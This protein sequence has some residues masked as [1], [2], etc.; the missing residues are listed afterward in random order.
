MAGRT[1]EETVIVRLKLLNEK[2]G[3]ATKRSGELLSNFKRKTEDLKGGFQRITEV[4]SKYNKKLD[5]IMQTTKTSIKKNREFR[6]EL[7][8]IMFGAKMV[9]NAMGNLL[10]PALSITGI[11]DLLNTVLTV[12]F[13]PTA[14]DLLDF[15]IYFAE[16]FIGLPEPVQKLL[17][18]FAMLMFAFFT[19]MSAKAAMGLFLDSLNKAVNGLSFGIKGLKIGLLELAGGYYLIK[20]VMTIAKEGFTKDAIADLMLGAG[21]IIIS[22][23]PLVGSFLI[24]GAIL[25]KLGV[26]EGFIESVKEVALAMQDIFSYKPGSALSHLKKAALVG[27]G[28]KILPKS[29]GVVS[30]AL[31]GIKLSGKQIGGYIPYEGLYN[32]HRGETVIPSEQNMSFSP[33]INIEVGGGLNASELAHRIRMELD[34]Q[35]ARSLA[36]LSRSR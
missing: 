30:G 3:A 24:V 17:G 26:W 5:R 25:L 14:L 11:F 19:F 20:A 33:V 9:A 22:R 10:Q 18:E 7:L 29:G 2:W 31:A 16:F 15:F 13:L 6:M 23:S 32:L 4:S 35:Y 36:N 12:M 34:D 27:L 21:L 28:E 1:Y 8:G